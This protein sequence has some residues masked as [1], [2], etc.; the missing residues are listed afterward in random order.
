MILKKK[1]FWIN[2]YNAFYQI[3][4]EKEK[5]DKQIIYKKK[6]FKIADTMFSLDDVEHGI[7]R[8]YRYKYSLGFIADLF[9]PKNN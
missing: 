8:R 3:L 4:R 7:L 9:P 1:T 2:I 6:L 5:V